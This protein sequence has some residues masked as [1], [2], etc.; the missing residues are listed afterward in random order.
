MLHLLTL[1]SPHV[2]GLRVSGEINESDMARIRSEVEARLRAEPKLAVYI[3]LDHFE[4]FTLRGFIRELQ[5]LLRYVNHF[6]RTALVG[7]G[8]KLR[9][10]ANI[11]L[12]CFPNLEVEH[13]SHIQRD[14]AL[15]WAREKDSEAFS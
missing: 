9:R 8:S 1:A 7:E 4:G 10:A 6:S 14:E 2:L 3:E 15:I 11:L 13:F 12:R 5:L